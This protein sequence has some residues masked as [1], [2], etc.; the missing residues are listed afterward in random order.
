ME[1][2][3]RRLRTLPPCSINFFL[4]VA[5]SLG[6]LS[7]SLRCINLRISFSTTLP[8]RLGSFFLYYSRS[9]CLPFYLSPIVGPFSLNVFSNSAARMINSPCRIDLNEINRE[10][11]KLVLLFKTQKCDRNDWVARLHHEG[12]VTIP[13]SL[14]SPPILPQSLQPFLFPTT[15]TKYIDF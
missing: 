4:S 7:T 5:Q 2:K 14:I 10:S 8:L 11:L 15:F 1:I 13:P 6:W 3:K 12:F 9:L